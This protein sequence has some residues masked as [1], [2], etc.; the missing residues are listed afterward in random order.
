VIDNIPPTDHDKELFLQ[1]ISSVLFS[2]I[3]AN[4]VLWCAAHARIKGFSYLASLPSR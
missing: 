1:D 4:V 3:V 2:I